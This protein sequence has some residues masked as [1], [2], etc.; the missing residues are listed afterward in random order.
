MV[1]GHC[2]CIMKKLLNAKAICI[3]IGY[4]TVNFD[5]VAGMLDMDWLD[6]EPS[7][8]QTEHVRLLRFDDPLEIVV[9][10]R[11]GTGVIMKPNRRIEPQ[12][13]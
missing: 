7:C 9:S 8:E 12:G 3:G 10:A 4:F 11:Q 6:A 13:S 2:V 5:N 1:L